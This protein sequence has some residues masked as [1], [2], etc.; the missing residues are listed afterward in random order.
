MDIDLPHLILLLSL[1]IA[2]V[3]SLY[4][5]MCALFCESH[6]K[7]NFMFDSWQFPMLLALFFDCI[8]FVSGNKA[9]RRMA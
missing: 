6:V 5:F 8:L 4:I 3:S 1:F 2:L 7:K 9:I